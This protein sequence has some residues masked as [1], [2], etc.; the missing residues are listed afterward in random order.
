M[1]RRPAKPPAKVT[2]LTAA[3][4]G[5]I[6]SSYAFGQMS[7]EARAQL[8]STQVQGVNT[9]ISGMVGLLQPSQ[10][11][12]LTTPQVQ[13]ISGAEVRYVPPSRIPDVTTSQIAEIPSSYSFSQ[14]SEDAVHAL[15]EQ[16]VLAINAS[17]YDQIKTRLTEEQRSWRP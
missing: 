17:Y 6:P 11:E 7:S 16:Q 12:Q 4:M 15:N 2:D 13:N 1:Q 3:Q 14:M 9:S 5:T 10:R 8:S